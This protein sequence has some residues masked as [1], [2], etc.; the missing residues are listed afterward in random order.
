MK[1]SAGILVYR[2]KDN[3]LEVLIAHMGSPWWA[4]KDK[5]AW[6]I[7]KGEYTDENP[8]DTAKKEFKEELGLEPPAGELIDLGEIRQNNNKAVRAWAVKADLDVSKTFSN[9]VAIEW[10][11][12]SGKTQEF[13]EIDRAAY[14][15]LDTA[16]KKII[17]GQIELL[18]RLAGK[19]GVEA[20]VSVPEQSSL[21]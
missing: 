15:N 6:S 10:P 5:G 16:A 4:K 1:T 2:T 9:T 20:R 8:L 21:F 14:F 17:P 13:P 18:N 12:S 7:P 19:L 11:P 3:Q